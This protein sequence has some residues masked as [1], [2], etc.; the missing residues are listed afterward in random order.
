M[1]RTGD[2]GVKSAHHPPHGMLQFHV[3][4]LSIDIAFRGHMQCLFNGAYIVHGWDDELCLGNQPIFYIVMVDQGAA[5]CFYQP[6]TFA[7][8]RCVGDVGVLVIE[9]L[10][11][12]LQGCSNNFE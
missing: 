6:K 10:C 12:D 2:A 1:R 5:R 9:R 7:V 4:A 11:Q 8:T 3:H